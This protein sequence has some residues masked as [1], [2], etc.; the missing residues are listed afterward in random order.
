MSQFLTNIINRHVSTD[1]V[2]R[3]RERSVFESVQSNFD[4]IPESTDF[5]RVNV[6]PSSTQSEGL[7][8][9]SVE[10]FK[11]PNT[12][13]DD[14]PISPKEL[15]PPA[16]NTENLSSIKPR[17]TKKSK[18]RIDN[19]SGNPVKTTKA[20]EI[21]KL[22]QVERRND[23][24]DL[25][26]NEKKIV[27]TLVKAKV[28]LS[29]SVTT[30]KI[31]KPNTEDNSSSNQLKRER[32]S[33]IKEIHQK[34]ISNLIVRNFSEKNLNVHSTNNSSTE[35]KAPTIKIQIGRIDIKAVKQ[36]PVKEIKAKKQN[37]S[38]MTLEQFLKK[39][40]DK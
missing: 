26:S 13:I 31:P 22:K 16:T 6:K 7:R 29:G 33:H 5:A 4:S 34:L 40:S 10:N 35:E 19:P 8:N 24:S 28:D 11:K 38:A 1:N 14:I 25:V 27:D 21:I 20:D 37:K 36:A 15:L 32:V 12:S 23:K 17:P 18:I 39:S 2:V 30:A 3:P 9:K